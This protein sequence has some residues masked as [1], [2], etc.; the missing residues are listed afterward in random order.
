MVAPE[1]DNLQAPAPVAHHP[2]PRVTYISWAESCSRSDHTAREFG[3]RSHMVYLPEYGSRPSTILLKYLGQWKA[4]ARILRDERPDV[5]F[6]MTPPLFASFPAFLYAWRHGARVVLDAH[7]AAFLHPR[8]RHLLWL[9]RWLCR[10]ASTT[11]VHNAHL[12]EVVRTAGAHSTIVPDVPIVY[13]EHRTVSALRERSPWRWC[14]R[15]TP[16]NRLQAILDAAAL[17][18]DV[19][20]FMTGNQKHLSA[21]L[22]AT[23]P[24]ERA[25]D[26]IPEHGRLR[27]VADDGRCRDDAHDPRPH[28][29]AGRLRG[30]LPGNAGRRVGLAH[31]PRVL[32]RGRSARRQQCREHRCRSARRAG[33]IRRSSARARAACASASSSRGATRGRPSSIASWPD[34]SADAQSPTLP[35]NEGERQHVMSTLT[36][37]QR[38]EAESIHIMREVVAE[39]ENPVMLYSIGKD[40]AAMLHIA[41]KAFYPA[42]P[43]FPLL[44]VDTTWKFRRDDPLPRLAHGQ[45]RRPSARAHQPGRRSTR[46]STRSPPARRCTP[47][48]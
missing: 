2:C 35:P 13:D 10:R 47:T 20:F 38:L 15:S 21:E 31:P 48:S 28:D 42:P 39:S 6:V 11:I 3:G 12:A 26:G 9:Q 23:H 22:K 8:W 25:A 14:A 33:P 16:T 17:V 7:T 1:G 44:H 37:L 5:V 24:V 30:H 41:M 46:A 36:H 18:P 27:W 45:A 19:Q 34:V 4:T 29:A 43:P 40:S 32:Q